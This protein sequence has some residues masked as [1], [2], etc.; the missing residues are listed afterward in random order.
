VSTFYSATG[1]AWRTLFLLSFCASASLLSSEVVANDYETRLL[2]ATRLAT[3][4]QSR[5]AVNAL[6]QLLVDYPQS[7]VGHSLRAELLFRLTGRSVLAT[8]EKSPSTREALE[9]L[10]DELRLRWRHVN[11][12]R[13]Q[14]ETA[15]P[16]N[17]LKPSVKSPF[18][19]YVDLPAARLYVFD[20]RDPTPTALISFYVTIGREGYGKQR[21]GDL[22]TPVGVYRLT[23]YKPGKSLHERYGY[24]ALTTDY[25]NALDKNLKRT[26]YGIWIHG[27]EPGWENRGPRASDGCITLSNT[28]FETLVTRF[29]MGQDTP[30]IIDDTPQWMSATALDQLRHEL[31]SSI[32]LESGQDQ[33]EKDPD[34]P[35]VPHTWPQ[36]PLTSFQEIYQYPAS[37]ATLITRRLLPDTGDHAIAIDEYWTQNASGTW[38]RMPFKP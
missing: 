38:E 20:T 27:T 36:S 8:T 16:S 13:D 11:K 4:G 17:L 34:L 28:D 1:R 23:G 35:G 24:G 7:R 37:D 14:A 2:E 33:L 29:P 12:P 10:D 25:P 5:E 22:K 9:P 18:A 32:P 21:E 31:E 3:E 30:V 26:G 6:D 15:L 19:I